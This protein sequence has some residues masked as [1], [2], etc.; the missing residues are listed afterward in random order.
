VAQDESQEA[1]MTLTCPIGFDTP[2]LRRKVST[3]YEQV[4][5]SPDGD[6]HFHRGLDYACERLRYDRVELESL[7]RWSTERFAG[8]ANPHRIGPIRMGET[9]LDVGS[10]AGMDLL[11]AAR[12]VGSEGRAIGVD[13]TAAMRDGALLAASEAGLADRIEVR[14]GL[15]EALPA[16]EASVDVVITNGVFNLCP[17]KQ[18]AFR[19]V[20]RVLRPGGRFYLAD[21]VMEGS[22]SEAARSDVDLWAA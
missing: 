18:A 9:V 3:T 14:D 19:E 8:V 4:A 22:L 2:S 7:P 15:A 21:V 5:E 20:Y 17:D 10:G 16:E 11:L 13:M 6:F 12:R 1:I